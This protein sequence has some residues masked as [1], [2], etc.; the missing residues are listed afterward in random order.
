M[1]L[2][3]VK[4]LSDCVIKAT[5][6]HPNFFMAAVIPSAISASLD[7]VLRNSGNNLLLE[8]WGDEDPGDICQNMWQSELSNILLSKL[9]QQY[10]V[11]Y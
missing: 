9:Q 1:R 7:T 2:T 5:L 4:I 11:F 10:I 6:D 8:R 3:N